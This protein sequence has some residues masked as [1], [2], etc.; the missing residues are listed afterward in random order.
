MAGDTM[1]FAKPLMGTNA[2]APAY[3]PILSNTPS[4]V[5]SAVRNTSTMLANVD[6]VEGVMFSHA[7]PAS[8]QHCPMT[9]IA[10]PTQNARISPCPIFDLGD[11][12]STSRA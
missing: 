9:Q 6:A 8:M 4:P 12:L 11:R 1:A 5:S 2:P 7:S 10:P 3:C